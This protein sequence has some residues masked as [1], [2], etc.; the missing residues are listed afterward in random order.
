MN[1]EAPVTRTEVPRMPRKA[2]RGR[3][4]AAFL[5]HWGAAWYSSAMRA[6]IDK[7]GR[8]VIPASIREKAG[9]TP[10]TEL[11]IQLDEGGVRIV[12]AVAGPKLVRNAEGRLV[13][14]PTVPASARPEV[15]FAALVEEE[16]ERWP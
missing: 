8:V 9:L 3:S 12:R 7:A 15:S 6:S 10:G 11:E 5:P 4:R 14:R 2:Y 16:R 13:A 1:P